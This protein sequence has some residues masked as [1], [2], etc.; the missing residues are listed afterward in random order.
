[1]NLSVSTILHMYMNKDFMTND[2][3]SCIG[4]LDYYLFQIFG[5]DILNIKYMNIIYD[6]N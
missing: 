3:T 1:M 5:K 4:F 2:K 6:E